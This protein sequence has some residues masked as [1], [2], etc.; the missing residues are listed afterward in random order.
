[1]SYAGPERR[2]HP[3]ISGR[4]IVSYRIMDEIDNADIS[5]T[6]NLSI[7][8]MLLTTN[9][10]LEPGTNLALEIRLPFDPNPI[11]IIGRVLESREITKNLIY[12]TR[13]TF[14]AVDERHRNIINETV[15]YYLK[16][17]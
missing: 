16:K 11:M 4:F 6:K 8:G 10:Q 3:R 13:L 2:K 14:L 15:G 1:M 12:D 7:G 17:G 5:Q 9:R